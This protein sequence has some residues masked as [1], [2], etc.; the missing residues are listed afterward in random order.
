MFRN[1]KIGF[2]VGACISAVLLLLQVVS[3]RTRVVGMLDDTTKMDFTHIAWILFMVVEFV[4]IAAGVVG[5]FIM[6]KEKFAK[7]INLY[8]MIYN[9]CLFLPLIMLALC[10]TGDFMVLTK[11]MADSNPDA[12]AATVI[13]LSPGFYIALAVSIAAPIA[14]HFRKIKKRKSQA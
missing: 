11:E 14:S 1:R 13:I 3:L 4:I 2:I 10:L 9:I 6:M 8:G 5:A 7:H 12:L